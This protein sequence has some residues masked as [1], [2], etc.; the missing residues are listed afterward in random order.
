MNAAEV[1]VTHLG[2]D[3]GSK[4]RR[5]VDPRASSSSSLNFGVFGLVKRRVVDYCSIA[6]GN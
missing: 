6:Y 3:S 2:E 4:S 1:K 5:D